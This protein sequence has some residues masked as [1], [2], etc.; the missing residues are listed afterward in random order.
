[1]L[2]SDLSDPSVKL[3]KISLALTHTKF[4]SSHHFS[5]LLLFLFLSHGLATLAKTVTYNWDIG[6]VTACPDGF[7]R[8]VIG[9]NGVWPCPVLEADR[10]DTIIVNIHNSLHN[11]TTSIHY[12]GKGLSGRS[13]M[14]VAEFYRNIPERH[15]PY[16]WCSNG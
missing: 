15:D 10:G 1:M 4:L 9:I 6:W 16:G 13:K 8:P 11:E 3:T 2:V 7:C 5:M 14:V 12:H